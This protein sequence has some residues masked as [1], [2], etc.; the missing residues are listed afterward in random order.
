MRY[1]EYQY[2]PPSLPTRR[3]SSLPK[4]ALLA[5]AAAAL[6][7]AAIAV[8]QRAEE[9][10]RDNPPLGRFITVDGV[11]MHYVERG[12]GQP[13]LL[14]HGTGSMVQDFMVSGLFDLAAG[15]YRV[16]AFDRPGHGYSERPR[17]KIWGPDTQAQLLHKALL[18]LGVDKPV[19]VGHSWGALVAIALGLTY[20]DFVKSLVLLSG[21]YY[22]SARPEV[23]L[24]SPPAIPLIG[25]L[26][27]YT[28][29]PPLSRLIWPA[30]RKRIFGP[31]PVPRRF[32][33]FPM[34]MM[35]RPSQLR[36]AAAESAMMIPA[37]FAMRKRYREL[38]MPVVIMAGSGDKVIDP[39]EQSERL[40]RELVQSDLHLR[41]GVGHMIHHLVPHEV[42]AAID[43]AVGANALDIE[44]EHI[45]ISPEPLQL[46]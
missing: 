5:G 41:S 16:I 11:R 8:R 22:P 7:G 6:V 9:A 43:Q 13:V 30:L 24:M 32:S 44:L 3:R 12:S 1:Y 42:M 2:P 29:S 34:E 19:V 23:P 33:A 25:D 10:Q 14:L 21:Y 15:K 37:A 38:Q 39:R 26:M 17:S 40:H 35:V 45:A 27:R 46:Q 18:R 36:A 20:P 31:A 4:M 28:V